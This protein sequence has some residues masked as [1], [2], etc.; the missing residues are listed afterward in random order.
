MNQELFKFMNVLFKLQLI[1]FAD[2][3]MTNCDD[4]ALK[5]IDKDGAIV[6]YTFFCW[7]AYRT[8]CESGCYYQCNHQKERMIEQTRV[9]VRMPSE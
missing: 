8:C 5:M 1:I 7:L 3:K 2:R 9:A 4:S 6:H